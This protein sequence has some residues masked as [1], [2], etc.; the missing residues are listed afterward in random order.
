M[1]RLG[2][3]NL[4]LKKQQIKSIF[5]R[6]LLKTSKS[7]VNLF[8]YLFNKEVYILDKLLNAGNRPFSAYWKRIHSQQPFL[9]KLQF[10]SSTYKINFKTFPAVYTC[11]N[12][13]APQDHN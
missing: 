4:S 10:L 9:Q 5:M 13:Q 8:I 2:V 7:F 1:G 12:N 6:T 3:L 11:T